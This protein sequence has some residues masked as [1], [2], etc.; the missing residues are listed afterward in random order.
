[1]DL[2]NVGAVID[3]AAQLIAELGGGVVREGLIDAYPAPA[4][5]QPAWRF[6][7][8]KGG[9]AQMEARRRRQLERA[10]GESRYELTRATAILDDLARRAAQ[11]RKK[12]PTKRASPQ[13]MQ[14]DDQMEFF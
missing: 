10:L 8:K 5:K 13:P 6:R 9:L 11:P 1:M 3:R 7:E 12:R 4:K 2:G 14:R